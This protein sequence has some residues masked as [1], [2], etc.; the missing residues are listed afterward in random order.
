[1]SNQSTNRR[2]RKTFKVG[3]RVTWGNG[4]VVYKVEKVVSDGVIV[5]EPDG[6]E[7][8]VHY[9]WTAYRTTYELRR[10]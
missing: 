1:M 3:D 2:I 10:A 9:Q 4:S 6:R 7:L 8:H 5:L